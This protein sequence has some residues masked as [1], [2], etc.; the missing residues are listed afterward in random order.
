MRLHA[1]G[2]PPVSELKSATKDKLIMQA[3]TAPDVLN[4]VAPKLEGTSASMRP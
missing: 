4:I 2:L 3:T 1:Q